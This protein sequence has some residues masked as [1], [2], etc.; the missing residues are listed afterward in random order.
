MKNFEIGQR[1]WDESNCLEIEIVA[2]N[3]TDYYCKT[4]EGA[5]DEAEGVESHQWFKASELSGLK[6]A[7]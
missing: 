6:P 5:S 7:R 2:S 1:F 4:L 3:E